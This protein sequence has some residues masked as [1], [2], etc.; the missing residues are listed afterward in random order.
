MVYHM[1]KTIKGRK[2]HYLVKNVRINNKWKKF[3][4]YIGKGNL[5]KSTIKRLKTKYSKILEEKVNSYLK[6]VDPLLSLLSEK[7]IEELESIKKMYKRT[8]KKMP[9]EVK[10]KFYEW[11][12]T[13]FTYNT[14]AIEGSTITLR[15]TSMILFDKIT[16]PGKT[17]REIKEVENHKKAFDFILG[18]KGDITEGFVCKVHKILTTDIL[19]KESCGKFRKVQVFIRG[20]DFKPP[21]PE[22]VKEEF[23]K[24]I[25]WYKK[26]KKRYHPVIVASYFHVAFECVHPFVDF[27]GRVGRLLLNFIL[28]KNGFPAIDVKNKERMKYYEALQ[29]GQKGNLKPFVSLIV[30]YLKEI[31]DYYR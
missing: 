1:E 17:L 5:S 16:P 31:I 13:K 6:S 7:E 12:L 30:K 3:T 26:N 27:N 4:V 10:N 19:P 18:Y 25:K 9:V 28:I 21:K 23:K 11:F 8:Y 2:Y 24:L 15:E 14:S 20:V 22:F 29:K